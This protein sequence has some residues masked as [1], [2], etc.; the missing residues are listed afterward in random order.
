MFGSATREEAIARAAERCLEKARCARNGDSLVMQRVELDC[1]DVMAVVERVRA[2]GVFCYA[3]AAA[4]VYE[5]PTVFMHGEAPEQFSDVAPF[6]TRDLCDAFLLEQPPA[7]V[8]KKTPTEMAAERPT[9]ERVL[10]ALLCVSAAMWACVLL[11]ESVYSGLTRALGY[12]FGQ[13]P[14]HA[15][16]RVAA[17]TCAAGNVSFVHYVVAPFFFI[18]AMFFMPY[19]GTMVLVDS[20]DSRLWRNCKE[21]SPVYDAWAAEVIARYKQQPRQQ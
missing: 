8:A 16:N 5:Q 14:V 9:R 15:L 11:G 20:I 18:V 6:A 10:I 1:A 7:E 3:I 17:S 19:V 2:R 13:A 4:S 21:P 12:A